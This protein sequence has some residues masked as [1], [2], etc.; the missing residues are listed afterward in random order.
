[1]RF[2]QIRA[3]LAV[4]PRIV[5]DA[6]V[7]SKARSRYSTSVAWRCRTR[8][9]TPMNRRAQAFHRSMPKFVGER[10]RSFEMAQRERV[11]A[12]AAR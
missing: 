12:R 7:L 1:M 4:E 2:T 8:W 9:T 5:D 3:Q 10:E 11:I 6:V